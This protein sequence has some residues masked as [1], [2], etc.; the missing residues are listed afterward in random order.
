[1]TSALAT[2]APSE[3]VRET[4]TPAEPLRL[5][6]GG[7]SPKAGWKILN[8]QPGPDV[9]YVGSCTDLEQFGDGTVAEVYASHVFEHLNYAQELP[10]TLKEINRILETKGKLYIS[11]P[12]LECLM[13]LAMRRDLAFSDRFM[14]MRMMFGGQV[15]EYDFHK[16]GLTW[17]FLC[18]FLSHAGFPYATRVAEHGL[19]PDTSSMR[20]VGELISLNVIAHKSTPEEPSA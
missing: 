15:D 7:R 13:Q 19:F 17:E 8:V 12:N 6:I 16:V 18:Y 1:M 14:V 2:V 11:V 10:H 5:H 20:F 4:S 3:N 9:D